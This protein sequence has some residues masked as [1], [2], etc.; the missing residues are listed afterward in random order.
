M[1]PTAKKTTFKAKIPLDW[2][3]NYGF[4]K[5][6]AWERYFF[7]SRDKGWFTPEEVAI[8]NDPKRFPY[9]LTTS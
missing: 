4:W 8:T 1:T 7:N 2:A 6:E 9:N 3:L 5:S